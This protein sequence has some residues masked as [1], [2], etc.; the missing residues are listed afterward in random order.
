MVTAAREAVRFRPLD[1]PKIKISKIYIK[2][3]L[4]LNFFYSDICLLVFL[5]FIF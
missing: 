1:F 3:S 4:S 2:K 5:L